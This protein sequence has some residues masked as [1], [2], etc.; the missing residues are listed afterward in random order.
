MPN[1]P[2]NQIEP[3]FSAS[4]LLIESSSS[5][6]SVTVCDCNNGKMSRLFHEE[7]DVS[8]R[9]S[10][11]LFGMAQ[12]AVKNVFQNN[13]HPARIIVGTGPGSY[14]G[15]RA[16]ISLAAGLALGWNVEYYGI[17]SL[18]GTRYC[19]ERR[20]S[21][22]QDGELSPFAV[23]GDAR[24]GQVFFAVLEQ[25]NTG[26]LHLTIPPILLTQDE[27]FHRAEEK[28]L[29]IHF[30]GRDSELEIHGP[31]LARAAGCEENL[32]APEPLYLKPPHI[33]TPKNQDSIP[34]F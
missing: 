19:D 34:R 8:R 30:F 23:C 17:C 28:N 16:G 2:A 4:F 9:E 1:N 20:L 14:N 6:M 11:P 13:G 5:H 18:L 29:P 22:S 27:A 12:R 15:I 25:K 24:G 7:T 33:T 32:T 26:V 21:E 3:K 31:L 10:A